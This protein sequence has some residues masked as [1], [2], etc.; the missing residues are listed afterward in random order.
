[1]IT[2][3]LKSKIDKLWLEF[4]AGGITNPLTVIEQIS[5]LMFA[6]MLD[7][8]EIAAEKR[9]QRMGSKDWERIF[10][11]DKQHLRWSHLIN[12]GAEEQ[13]NIVQSAMFRF[14]REDMVKHST[15]GKYLQDA[16]CV[17]QKASLLKTAINMINDLPL[18]QGTPRAIFTNIC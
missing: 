15:L 5:F 2:G 10:P 17:I 8:R 13:L 9:A 1:M 11:D 12:L 4:W 3:T 18:M 7:M 14:F 6:R 16:Q